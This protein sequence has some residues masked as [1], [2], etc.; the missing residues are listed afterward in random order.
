MRIILLIVIL[1]FSNGC[2]QKAPCEP[3]KI[4]IKAKIPRLKTL[5]TIKPYQIQDFSV[6]D[7]KYYKVSKK[8]LHGASRAS[9]KRIHNISYYEHQNARF[10]KEFAQ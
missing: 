10:N 9:Q 7:D 6:I 4:Y 5:Y 3:K 2:S 8:E 1:L